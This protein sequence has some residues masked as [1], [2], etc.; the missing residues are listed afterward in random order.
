MASSKSTSL[1]EVSKDDEFVDT[2]DDLLGLEVWKS[3]TH[4][5]KDAEAIAC[6]VKEMEHRRQKLEEKLIRA[7]DRERKLMNE[8]ARLIA[9]L[10]IT[11][12]NNVALRKQLAEMEDRLKSALKYS[13]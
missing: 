3:V 10:S 1:V 8:H 13:S 5:S 12:E 4:L 11:L 6:L 7:G 9:D 2:S